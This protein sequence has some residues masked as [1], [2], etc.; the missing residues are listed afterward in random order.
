MH[1]DALTMYASGTG[2][3]TLLISCL[4]GGGIG[5]ATIAFA[6]LFFYCRRRYRNR[7]ALHANSGS[8]HSKSDSVPLIEPFM[9]RRRTKPPSSTCHARIPRRHTFQSIGTTLYEAPPETTVAQST[10]PPSTISPHDAVEPAPDV[11]GGHGLSGGRRS[12]RTQGQR[13]A[14]P[15]A[16]GGQKFALTLVAT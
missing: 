10:N 14:C 6:I 5:L 3:H 13:K 9:I 4:A 7:A 12:R 15:R 2:S 8:D 11:A 16:D 1:T